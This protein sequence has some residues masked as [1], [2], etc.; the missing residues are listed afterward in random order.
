[1]FNRRLLVVEDDPMVSALLSESLTHEGFDVRT[2]DTAAMARKIADAFDPDVALVDVVLGDGPSGLDLAHVLHT[3]FPGIGILMLS[4]HPD[5][6]TAGFGPAELPPG[7]GFLRK[8]SITDVEAL[9]SVIASVTASS[10]QP[11]ADTKASAEPVPESHPLAALSKTQLAVLKLMS[12]GY[13]NSEIA[14]HR[15]TSLS[16]I[17]QTITSIFKNLGI[18]TRGPINPRVEA[19]RQYILFAGLPE[20]RS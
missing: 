18:A 12:E 8:S 5:P 7:A 9:L 4:R 2:A 15:K 14:L 13:A 10:S 11:V 6:S 1:M 20:R 19:V 16:A 17:E 3:R